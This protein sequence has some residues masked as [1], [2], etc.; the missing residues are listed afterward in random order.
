M[1]R[2]SWVQKS[3]PPISAS[4]GWGMAEMPEAFQWVAR[5]GAEYNEHRRQVIL[6]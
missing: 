1:T 4:S 5:V 2:L 6:A 3:K